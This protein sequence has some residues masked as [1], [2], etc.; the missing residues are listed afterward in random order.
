MRI[1]FPEAENRSNV[2]RNMVPL[3]VDLE[4]PA[5]KWA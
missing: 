5:A 3:P 2:L 4:K 1:P